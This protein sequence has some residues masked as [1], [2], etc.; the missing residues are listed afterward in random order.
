MKLRTPI[1]IHGGKNYLAKFIIDHFPLN[2]QELT[3]IEPFGGGASVLLN[4]KLSKVEIYNDLY[5]PTAN[6]FD[7]LVNKSDEVL[8]LISGIEYTSDCFENAKSHKFEYGSVNSAVNEIILRRMSRGGLKKHFSWSDRKRGGLPGDVNAWNNFK[9]ELPQTINRLKNVQVFSKNGLDLIQS[10][11]N[12]CLI[13]VDPPY[14]KATRTAKNA[15]ECEMSDQEHHILGDIL[16]KS[17]SKIL[18]SGYENDLYRQMFVN[19]RWIKKEMPNN[20]GQ[21]QIKQRRIEC[22]IVNF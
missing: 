5:Q 1:K 2:Y 19:W 13:Y 11:G 7:C 10:L 14:L 15:Y 4:K 20:S 18:L 22:L 17:K 8:D 21:S 6:I 12:E 16:N 9:K 3:Y